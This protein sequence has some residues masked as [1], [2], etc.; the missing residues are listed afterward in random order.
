[1]GDLKVTHVVL[2]EQGIVPGRGLAAELLRFADHQAVESGFSEI[3]LYTNEK[4]LRN[5]AIYRRA[6]YREIGRRPHPNQPGLLL[7]DMAKSPG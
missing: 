1:M 4:M 3:R 6:G 2:A 7:V 5:Q